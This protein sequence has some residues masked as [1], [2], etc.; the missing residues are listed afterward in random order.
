MSMHKIPLTTIE[1]AGLRAHGLDIGTPS[2]LSDAFRQGVAFALKAQAGEPD[3][4]VRRRPSPGYEVVSSSDPMAQP[5]YLHPTTERREPVMSRHEL[6]EAISKA[7]NT[8][9][10]NSNAWE[11]W[12]GTIMFA[13]AALHVIENTHPTTEP[14]KTGKPK[15]G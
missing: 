9:A 13:E 7:M 10:K 6:R 1:E 12:P 15:L 3:F 8:L 14:V 5:A 11:G 4:Y 2:Q